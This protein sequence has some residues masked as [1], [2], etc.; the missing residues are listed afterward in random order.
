ML[1]YVLL[2]DR[3]VEIVADRGI[4]ARVSGAQWQAICREMEGLFAAGRFEDGAI[5][6]V[7]G[8][9]RT[10]SATALPGPRRRPQRAARPPDPDLGF[11]ART[12]RQGVRYAVTALRSHAQWNRRSRRR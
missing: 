5:A 12:S 9:C 3:R 1:I 2:A 11:A 10:C 4:I 7:R 6:G 8:R